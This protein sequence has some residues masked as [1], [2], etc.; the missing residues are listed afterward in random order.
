MARNLLDADISV[1]DEYLAFQMERREKNYPA[2][3]Y[4]I[5][6]WSL[7]LLYDIDAV[8]V[9]DLPSVATS[10]PAPPGTSTL[11]LARVAYLLTWN[12]TTARVVA[13]ALRN[14]IRVRVANEPFVLDGRTFGVGT[15]IVRV[16]DHDPGLAERLGAIAARH[17]AEVVAANTGFVDSGISLGSNQVRPLVAPRVLLAWDVPTDTYS[18][19]WTR[20]VLERHLGQPVSIV[21]VASISKV[22]LDSFD[23]IVLPSGD[24]SSIAPPDFAGQLRAWMNDGGILITLS[25]ASR[26]AAGAELVASDPEQTPE[27]TPGA[28]A[29]VMLD[30]QHWLSAGSDGEVQMLVNGRRMLSPVSLDV[31][32]NAGVYA[33]ADRLRA[34]GLIWDDVRDTLGGTAAVI[35]QRAG[36]GGIVAFAE[37]PNYR[38]YNEASMLLFINA[39][40]IGPAHL[41]IPGVE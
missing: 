22:T 2:Q 31:G 6:A 24:Y 23:V 38:T 1:P 4:D 21:R 18:A 10:A 32:V 11:P 14:G 16:P 27:R 29:R 17:G 30:T 9:D 3:V 35:F 19:G 8:L 41:P 28:L 20:F 12:V 39:V 7:P 13:E 37:D 34:S 26:W 5:S 36:R 15:A 40:L 25:D 33:E